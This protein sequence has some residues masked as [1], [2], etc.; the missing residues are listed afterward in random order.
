[1]T[2]TTMRTRWIMPVT[3]TKI[4]VLGLTL[5]ILAIAAS[6]FLSGGTSEAMAPNAKG[7]GA[8]TQE[9][10]VAPAQEELIVG[11]HQKSGMLLKSC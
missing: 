2:T 1:M 9:L 4:S 3:P 8:A 5:S 7:M 11:T 10:Q 6:A